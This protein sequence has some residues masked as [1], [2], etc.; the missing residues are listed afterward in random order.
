M[1]IKITTSKKGK[2]SRLSSFAG[3]LI[4]LI[5]SLIGFYSVI[6]GGELSGGIPFIP[7]STNQV[8]GKVSIF[9]GAIFTGL[10]A[11]IAFKE[12]FGSG[13]HQNRK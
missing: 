10:L 2:N 1:S 11:V 6:F 12:F 9:G 7:E 5:L 13:K 3:G 8:I 4:C